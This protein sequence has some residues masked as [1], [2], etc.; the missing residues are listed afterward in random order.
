MLLRRA[1]WRMVWELVRCTTISLISSLL[2]ISLWMPVRPRKPVL[3]QALQPLPPHRVGVLD[4]VLDGDDLERLGLDLVERR[5]ERGRFARAGRPG[6]EDDPVRQVDELLEGLVDVLE[7]AD[8]GEV[9]DHAPLVE[10]AH[11]D[12]LAV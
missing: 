1:A 2:T 10:E 4:R 12:P 9:E 8:V 7:H 6:D 5:V 3:R 11:D